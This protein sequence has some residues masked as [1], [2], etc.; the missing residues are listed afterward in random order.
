LCRK[1]LTEALDVYYD[2]VS[3][4]YKIPYFLAMLFNTFYEIYLIKK[5]SIVSSDDFRVR[6]SIE[7]SKGF[8][9]SG[10]KTIISSISEFDHDF[11]TGKI[12]QESSM[13]LLLSIIVNS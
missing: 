10:L 3:L 2:M 9:V 4:K 12:D 8:T 7:Y 11:K 6:K 5:K 13:V 1:N